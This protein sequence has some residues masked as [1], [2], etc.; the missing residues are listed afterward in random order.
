MH[1]MFSTRRE[2]VASERTP[3]QW[4]RQAAPAHQDPLTGGVKKDALLGPEEGPPG[5]AT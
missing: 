1:V 3:E 5:V 4:F 2:D